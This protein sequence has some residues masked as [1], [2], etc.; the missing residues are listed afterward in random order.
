MDFLVKILEKRQI[1]KGA[2]AAVS[3]LLRELNERAD[4]FGTPGQRV[5]VPF[6]QEIVERLCGG[7]AKILI[8]LGSTDS[9]GKSGLLFLLFA[10]VLSKLSQHI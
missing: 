7:M 5:C 2:G 6:Q 10:V 1:V 9:M 8:F 4:K 3:R